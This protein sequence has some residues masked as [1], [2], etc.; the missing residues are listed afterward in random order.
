MMTNKTFLY[1]HLTLIFTFFLFFTVVCEEFPDTIENRYVKR[2]MCQDWQTFRCWVCC[3]CET[4]TLCI[5]QLCQSWYR[6]SCQAFLSLICTP[7]LECHEWCCHCSWNL[8][9]VCF[10]NS[11]LINIKTCFFLDFILVIRCGYILWT[12]KYQRG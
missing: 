4:S 5:T 6:L 9:L 8:P 10:W 7:V 2:S 11:I 12:R 3:L 1:F